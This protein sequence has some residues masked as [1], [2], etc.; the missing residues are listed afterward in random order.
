MD[1]HKLNCVCGVC[2]AIRG[3]TKGPNNPCFRK[4]VTLKKYHCKIC[5]TEISMK[6]ALYGKGYCRKCW[7]KQP[8]IRNRMSLAKTGT[9]PWN[10]GVKG[11]KGYWKGKSNKYII[12]KHHIDGNKTNNLESNFLKLPQGQHRSLHWR[13][14]QYLVIINKVSDYLK[15]FCS[16]YKIIKTKISNCKVVHHIDCNRENNNSRNLW[17]LKDKK[18]H[19]K[20]HQEAYKYL[21]RINAVNDYIGWFL[22]REEEKLPK[23]ETKEELK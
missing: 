15:E 2:K 20:L 21:V 19:N 8:E 17:Y 23:P 9:L 7:S 4:G 22:L 12:S 5:S 6:S 11:Q 13:G 18:I 10:K 1:N 16:K 14:Y 3:E